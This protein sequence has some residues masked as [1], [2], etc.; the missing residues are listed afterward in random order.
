MRLVLKD[1]DFQA[2]ERTSDEHFFQVVRYVERNALGA[3][4]V[5]RVQDWR[6]SSL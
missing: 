4:L 5:P 2:F 3:N 1:A 6:W